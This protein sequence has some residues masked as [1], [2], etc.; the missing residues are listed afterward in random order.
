MV[1]AVEALTCRR[2]LAH[3][4]GLP[5]CSARYFRY[6]LGIGTNSAGGEE[7]I[8][9]TGAWGAF[10]Y[11]WPAGD[12]AIA[13]TVHRR[14]MDRTALLESVI[15]ALRRERRRMERDALAGGE[16]A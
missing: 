8:G 16:D 7:F 12:A 14:G 3:T 9:A 13:G 10:A 2:V 1:V 6:G 15:G 11:F 5:D 4:S